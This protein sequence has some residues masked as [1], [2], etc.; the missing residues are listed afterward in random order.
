MGEPKSFLVVFGPLVTDG[1]NAHAITVKM[2]EFGAVQ[3]WPGTWVLSGEATVS[4]LSDALGRLGGLGAL[5]GEQLQWLVT[6][7]VDLHTGFGPAAQSAILPG[8]MD[9]PAGPPE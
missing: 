7:A 3:L 5:Q 8:P 9:I 2:L 4:V 1:A 6:E